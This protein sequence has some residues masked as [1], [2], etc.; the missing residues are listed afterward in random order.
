MSKKEL[1]DLL[2]QLP[3][4]AIF[5][6]DKNS[7]FRGCNKTFA[8]MLN[9]PKEEIIGM[10]EPGEHFIRDDKEVMSSG[11]PMLDLIEDHYLGDGKKETI[12]T[13]K[14]PWKDKKGKVIGVIGW[15]TK[16]R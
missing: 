7:V 15:T 1:E 9:I 6:K 14:G 12:R 5:W 11:K 3:G 2:D 10:K 8:E 4:I 16:V 13:Q